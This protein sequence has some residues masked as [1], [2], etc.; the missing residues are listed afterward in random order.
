V[1]TSDETSG[2]LVTITL[3][4]NKD[5]YSN[6]FVTAVATTDAGTDA[7]TDAATTDTTTTGSG[8]DN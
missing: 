6:R 7:G 5:A 8:A 3:H 2:Y 4:V 1:T